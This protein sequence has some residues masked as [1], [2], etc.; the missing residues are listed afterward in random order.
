MTTWDKILAKTPLLEVSRFSR[1]PKVRIFAKNESLCPTGSLKARLAAFVVWKTASDNAGRRLDFFDYSPGVCNYGIALASVCKSLGHNAHI[2]VGSDIPL[3]CESLLSRDGAD[4]IKI[5]GVSEWAAL[6]M[7]AGRISASHAG[8]L[9]T[10]QYENPLGPDAYYDS[11]GAELACQLRECGVRPDFFLATV[12]TGGSI[13]G[14]SRKL[15][16]NFDCKTLCLQP[17]S[18]IPKIKGARMLAWPSDGEAGNIPGV[19]KAGIRLVD[20]YAS[21]GP[22]KAKEFSECLQSE[23][24]IDVSDSGAMSLLGAVELSGQMD[25][26]AIVILFP[27]ISRR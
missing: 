16:E 2:L 21:I 1:N 17:S 12:G 11:T 4:I 19:F 20:G 5:V 14:L 18:P 8:W 22:A 13:I 27:A 23:E 24:N 15:K 6:R 7:E 26:G 9:W 25:E 3:N 10:N